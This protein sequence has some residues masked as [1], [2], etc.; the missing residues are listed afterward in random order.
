M[1]YFNANE[2]RNN[3]KESNDSINNPIDISLPIIKPFVGSEPIK[4]IVLG[5]DPTIKNPNTRKN[6]TCTLNLDKE[7]SLR[8]YISGICEGLGITIENVYATNL[9]KYFY[10]IPP[11]QTMDVLYAHLEPNLELLK[12]ELSGYKNI[13]II[14]L[15]EPVLQLLTN[16]KAKVREY[17]DYNPKTGESNGNF[18]FC[19]ASDNKLARD[20]YPFPH[21][22]SIRKRFYG[23]AINEYIRI[24]K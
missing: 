11:A 8:R 19:K 12:E 6:I 2:V 7:N 9:F 16:P 17:W 15:G 14:T 23:G 13:P 20:F 24:V 1:N 5:Q 21:Q 22:P 3:L 10:S 4:L 18:T